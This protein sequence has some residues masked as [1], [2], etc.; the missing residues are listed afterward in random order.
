[1]SETYILAY[2]NTHAPDRHIQ[3]HTCIDIHT[4]IDIHA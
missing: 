4:R 2:W 1:M 3:T